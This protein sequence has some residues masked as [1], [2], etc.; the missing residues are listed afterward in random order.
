[1]ALRTTKLHAVAPREN[2]DRAAF[3]LAFVVGVVGGIILKLVDAQTLNSRTYT[4]LLLG[5][6]ENMTCGIFPST[7]VSF[8]NN[9]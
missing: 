2:L 7:Q 8:S 9:S 1:M 6:G 4:I 3:V 5:S